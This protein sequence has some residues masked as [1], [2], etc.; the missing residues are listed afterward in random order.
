[1]EE[2]LAP[3]VRKTVSK[4]C[5]EDKLKMFSSF[6]RNGKPVECFALHTALVSE[7]ARRMAKR[8]RR[9]LARVFKKLSAESED[10]VVDVV[11]LS[12][13]LHDVGK[14]TQTYHQGITQPRHEL[15]SA[16]A[17][18]DYVENLMGERLGAVVTLSVLL[19]HSPMMRKAMKWTLLPF[20]TGDVCNM[21]L[22]NA[23]VRFLFGADVLMKEMLESF[24]FDTSLFRLPDVINRFN[25][26]AIN[27][28][29][30]VID[31]TFKD[32]KTLG[33]LLYRAAVGGVLACLIPSD[34]LAARKVRGSS[35][36]RFWEIVEREVV[37][38]CLLDCSLQGMGK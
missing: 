33:G 29:Q 36:S 20:L 23:E 13:L 3:K 4:W 7:I 25:C 12:A 37:G 27:R 16:L 14:L 30:L 6:R 24:G 1:M 5:S 31:R 19:H 2:L 34:Y 11:V 18:F 8:R 21:L 38:D 17:T 35:Y 28:L 9:F 32:G 10:K 26:K 22:R 15:V